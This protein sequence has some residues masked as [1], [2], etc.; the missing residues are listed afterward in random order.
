MQNPLKLSWI[1]THIQTLAPS[2]AH[3]VGAESQHE[4]TSMVL[5]SVEQRVQHPDSTK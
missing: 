4:G 2:N 5:G 3:G 1:S